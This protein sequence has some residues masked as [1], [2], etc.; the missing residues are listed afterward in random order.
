MS[1]VSNVDVLLATRNGQKFIREFLDSLANQKNVTVSLFVSDDSSTDS[2]LV[3]VDSFRE[4]FAKLMILSGPNTGPANNFLHL[5]K[6]SSGR[7]VAFADQD[8]IWEENH[9]FNSISRIKHM[10]QSPALTFSPTLEF[11]SKNTRIKPIVRHEISPNIF[12]AENVARGCTM[13]FNSVLRDLINR[14]VPASHIMHDWWVALVVSSC[15]SVV[16]SGSPEVRYRI[17]DDNFIGNGRSSRRQ[18][19]LKASQLILKSERWLPLLQ[20]EEAVKLF[21]HQMHEEALRE[22]RIFISVMRGQSGGL[23]RLSYLLINR[24]RQ[25]TTEDIFF[26]LFALVYSIGQRGKS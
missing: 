7:F 23:K 22:I 17:H 12:F 1:E 5:M 26:K 9:L 14:Y 3:I 16:Y 15:G 24:F 4:K 13:V 2:T 21:E 8:D 11:P 6:Y 20:V 25:N 18:R 10:E 19:I